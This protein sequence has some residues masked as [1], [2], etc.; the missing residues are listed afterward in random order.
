[1]RYVFAHPNAWTEE[2]S[3]Y[4][5]I[6]LSLLGASLAS[7]RG[8]HFLFD[9]AVNRL[10]TSMRRIVDL[11]VSLLVGGSLVGAIMLGTELAAAVRFQRSPALEIPM[12]W[13]YAALPVAAS[14]MLLHL[15]AGR[16]GA[17]EGEP[18]WASH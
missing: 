17:I 16:H 10:P 9:S 14:L 2:L 8:A 3:R 1:M 6:W 5:F 7:K 13:V 4:A 18:G 11:A 12:V 15:V